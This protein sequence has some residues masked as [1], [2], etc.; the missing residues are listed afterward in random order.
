MAYLKG[1]TY[2]DGDLNVEGSLKVNK[3]TDLE[4]KNFPYTKTI[5][6]DYLVRFDGTDAGITASQLKV[7]DAT[8]ASQKQV[9]VSVLA[10]GEATEKQMIVFE[11]V[12]GKFVLMNI[13]PKNFINNN[14][15]TTAPSSFKIHYDK[16]I[17]Y[18]DYE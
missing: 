18:W 1:G 3:L 13:D 12:T 9:Q 6:S 16:E 2:V 7:V 14:E 5:K 11:P 8:V 4:G 17:P 15:S 10:N